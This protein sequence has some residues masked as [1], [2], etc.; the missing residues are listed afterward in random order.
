MM[1]HIIIGIDAIKVNNIHMKEHIIEN[2][3]K[4]NINTKQYVVQ[5]VILLMIYKIIVMDL[6]I[7]NSI[8]KAK[9]LK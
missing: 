6:E 9:K 4:D 7:I 2:I 8:I 3:I 1:H 5:Q